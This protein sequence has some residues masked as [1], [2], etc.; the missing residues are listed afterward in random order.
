MDRVPLLTHN[1]CVSTKACVQA[2]AAALNVPVRF[3]HELRTLL[4]QAAEPVDTTNEEDARSDPDLDSAGSPQVFP[5]SAEVDKG[6]VETS[7]L[8]TALMAAPQ[9][10]A[11]IS[12]MLQWVWPLSRTLH[13]SCIWPYMHAV[14]H[15]TRLKAA[16][17]LVTLEFFMQ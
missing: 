6:Y 7:E 14:L 12:G 3:L 17:L 11:A 1:Y 15:S 9:M 16:P 8:Q 10:A 2:E 5:D 13:G 4:P